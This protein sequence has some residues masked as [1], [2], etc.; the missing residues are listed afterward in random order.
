MEYL[1]SDYI[2]E[3]KNTLNNDICNE[4]LV[5]LRDCSNSFLKTTQHGFKSVIVRLFELL[6]FLGIQY[7]DNPTMVDYTVAMEFKDISNNMLI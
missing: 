1:S 7:F 3:F 5:T 4:N 6:R 2:S